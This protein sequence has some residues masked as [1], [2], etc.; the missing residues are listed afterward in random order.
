MDE[1][2]LPQYYEILKLLRENNIN[3]EIFLD[4]K[5]NLGKQ[6]QFA[7]RKSLPLAVICGSDEFKENTITIKN[8]LGVKGVNNQVTVPKEKLIDEIKKFL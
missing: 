3:S 8:L 6:L 5:K 7:N 2:F 4:Y 1:K